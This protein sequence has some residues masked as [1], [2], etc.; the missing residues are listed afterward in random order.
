MGEGAGSAPRWGP[1]R[2]LL[3]ANVGL[4]RLGLQRLYPHRG[5]LPRWFSLTG[6]SLEGGGRLCRQSGMEAL[7]IV[8]GLDEIEDFPASLLVGV[9]VL[10]VDHLEF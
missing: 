6:C 9:K 5:P 4:L 7:A 8:E 1:S 2:T 3:A 10:A